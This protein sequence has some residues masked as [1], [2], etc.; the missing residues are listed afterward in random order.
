MKTETEVI[1]DLCKVFGAE[2]GKI[3]LNNGIEITF[4]YKT[5]KTTYNIKVTTKNDKVD[6]LE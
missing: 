6:L 1:A 5:G 4:S 2:E 3:H